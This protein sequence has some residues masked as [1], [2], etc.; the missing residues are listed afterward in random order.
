MALNYA[1]SEIYTTAVALCYFYKKNGSKYVVYFHEF[2][3]Q[4]KKNFPAIFLKVYKI[5]VIISY[6]SC[7]NLHE[8][9]SKVVCKVRTLATP[10]NLFFE[11]RLRIRNKRINVPKISC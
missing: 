2:V 4:V 3:V 5:V 7:P 9:W 10:K 11:F 1:L 8:K 6:K